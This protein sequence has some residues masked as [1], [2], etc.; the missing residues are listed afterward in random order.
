[1]SAK[2]RAKFKKLES[3]A[4]AP[5]LF[6]ETEGDTILVS[7]GSAYGSAREATQQLLESGKKVGHLHIKMVYPLQQQIGEILD[8]YQNVYTVELNDQG[9]Y[10]VG[11][12]GMLLRAVT[13]RSHI[14]SIC[15]TDGLTFK[16][17]EILNQLEA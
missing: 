6:G 10:G 3:E 9:I 13:A 15:K 8:Q 14:R 12:L 16:V 1:M 4:P 17:S 5:E 7:W 11:Q 2:R